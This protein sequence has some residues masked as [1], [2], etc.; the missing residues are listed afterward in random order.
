VPSRPDDPASEP[1]RHAWEALRRY[2]R[3]FLC[4]FSDSDPITAGADR[5]FRDEI[6]GATGQPH[7]T[8]EGAGHFLQ[9]DRGARLAAVVA[10]FVAATT[11]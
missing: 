9:E 7:T 11:R 6:P 10:D 3:P 5:L 8:I 4:T 2:E 1:N